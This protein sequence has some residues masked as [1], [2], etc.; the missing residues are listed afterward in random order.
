[1]LF[2]SF[3]AAKGRRAGRKEGKRSIYYEMDPLAS[4]C[5]KKASEPHPEERSTIAEPRVKE[6]NC[7]E[8][9]TRH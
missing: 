2:A 7:F 9:V 8:L 5:G 4:F 1:M 3:G 6:H